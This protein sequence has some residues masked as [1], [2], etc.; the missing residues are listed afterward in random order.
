[1][2]NGLRYYLAAYNFVAFI[3]WVLYLAVFVVNGFDIAGWPIILLNIAQ[4][5]AVLEILHAVLKWVKS[6]IGSTI[7]Q[8]GSRLLVVALIDR[9]ILRDLA[10][11]RALSYDPGTVMYIGI[12]I[13]SLAWSITEIIRYSFY[14]LALFK[15]QPSALLWMRYTFFIALYPLGV[16]GEW[17]IFLA[18]IVAAGF[19]FNL[20]TAF[21]IFLF[22]AYAYYFPVLYKYMWKQRKLKLQ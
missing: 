3:F 11:E 6:P 18:P 7:A 14:F 12:L 4:G 8:I 13:V 20:Y 10:A 1:M 5:L 15:K 19:I 21:V 16:T 2:N 9:D 17:F 22:V